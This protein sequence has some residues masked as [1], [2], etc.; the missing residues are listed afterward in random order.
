[1][2]LSEDEIR[3]ALEQMTPMGG[4]FVVPPAAPSWDAQAAWMGE[5]LP[6]DFSY[7]SDLPPRILTVGDLV[8]LLREMPEEMI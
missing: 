7:S 1:M 5:R 3:R 8:P 2:L 6:L 4:R